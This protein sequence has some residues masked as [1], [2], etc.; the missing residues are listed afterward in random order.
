M[1]IIHIAHKMLMNSN[2]VNISLV[3]GTSFPFNLAPLACMRGAHSAAHAVLLKPSFIFTFAGNWAL[4][5][6]RGCVNRI[7]EQFED[8]FFS[9]FVA[10][11]CDLKLLLMVLV[12]APATDSQG[13][14]H[15][16]G[17]RQQLAARPSQTHKR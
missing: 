9:G 7:D 10:R 2:C 8:D 12:G 4:R 11:H 14:F 1:T 16:S 3:Y 15:F 6:R 13:N 17:F 5:F